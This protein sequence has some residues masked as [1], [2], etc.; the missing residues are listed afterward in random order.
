M[1]EYC[2]KCMAHIDG[3]GVCPVCGHRNSG[4][5]LSHCLVPGTVLR[6]KFLVGEMLGEGGF[7]ITYIGRDLDLDIKVAIKEY[8]PNG[9]ASRNNTLSSYLTEPQ[10]EDRRTF[11][12]KG[13][14]SFLMEARSLAKFSGEPGIVDVR[15]FFEENNTAYIVMEYLEGQTLK[16]FLKQNGR[17]SFESIAKMLRP[18]MLSLR[19]V[20]KAG[21]IHRDISPDNI[22][23]TAKNVKLLD[24]G[25]ARYVSAQENKSLSVILKHGFAPEEQYRSKGKQGPWTDIYALCAT[26]YMSIT[27]I[28]PDDATDRMVKDELKRP[29]D[30]GIA[31]DPQAENAIMKGLSV[32]F[33]NRYQSM[34]ELISALFEDTTKAKAETD[35]SYEEQTVMAE[36]QPYSESVKNS[37]E[38][39]R[40]AEKIDDIAGNADKE[41]DNALS[42][43][44]SDASANVSVDHRDN[45][46]TGSRNEQKE[47]DALRAKQD[48]FDVIHSNPQRKEPV[49]LQNN[50][51]VP[52]KKKTVLRIVLDLVFVLVFNL[53]YFVCIYVPHE[54]AQWVSYAFVHVAYLNMVLI[55]RFSTRRGKSVAVFSMTTGTISTIYFGVELV[56][57]LIMLLLSLSALVS[58]IVQIILLA[59]YLLCLLPTWIANENTA[60]SEMRQAAEIAFIKDSAAKVQYLINKT[61]DKAMQRKI[62]HVYDQ[63]HS[64]PSKSS[65]RVYHLERAI[66]SLVDDLEDAVCNNNEREIERVTS[67]LMAIS[68]ERNRI[69]KTGA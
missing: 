23:L 3:D 15:D 34:D 21:I 48:Y 33:V 44:R 47:A 40:I 56:V 49:A 54:S 37:V 7:G 69:L 10:T 52:I 14:T 51:S 36:S 13:K 46:K 1:V 45:Y 50:S 18:V 19:E 4:Q 35:H 60:E 58:A 42:R 64:S 17:Q 62:E 20:H 24:F 2:F 12:E 59:I 38:L 66:S 57:G 22:M 41:V 53:I 67:E 68:E 31:V 27:G 25:A 8:Y 63:L 29:S 32:F 55:P 28:T 9:Y 5:T 16:S 26:I 6:G 39:Q 11:F 65:S 61:D 30:M 43:R